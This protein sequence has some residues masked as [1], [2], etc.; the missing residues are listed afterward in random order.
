ML[1]QIFMTRP[2]ENRCCKHT[3]EL[4][5]ELYNINV[6]LDDFLASQIEESSL[7]LLAEASVRLK[8]LVKMVKKEKCLHG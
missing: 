2:F 3:K 6:M 7:E 1:T 4:L 5:D 8:E